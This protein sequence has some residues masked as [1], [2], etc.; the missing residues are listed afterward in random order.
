MKSK[1]LGEV[2]FVAVEKNIKVAN[3]ICQ[4]LDYNNG[5]PIRY[6]ALR[7]AL[8]LVAQKA[9]QAG[10]GVHLPR[11]GCGLAGGS[12]TKVEELVISELVERGI[13]VVVYNLH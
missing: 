3:M 5:P 11:I 7:D 8:R 12:W 10:A 9:I 13:Y 6:N 1:K 4:V 2:Q